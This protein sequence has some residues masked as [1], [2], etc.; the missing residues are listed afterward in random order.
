M[1]S[2]GAAYHGEQWDRADDFH[3]PLAKGAI[4]MREQDC[5]PSAAKDFAQFTEARKFSTV[6]ADPPWQFMNRTGKVAPEH[7]RLSRYGTLKVEEIQAIPVSEAVE[8]KS[9]LYLCVP[10]K[11]P[12]SGRYGGDGSLGLYLQDQSGLAQGAQGRR[13]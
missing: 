12:D 8:V 3:L 7:K 6:L 5:G 2:K 10:N 13:A 4:E 1:T 9:H 11:C